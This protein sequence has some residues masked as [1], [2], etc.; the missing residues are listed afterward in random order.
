MNSGN[1]S[2]NAPNSFGT[3]ALFGCLTAIAPGSPKFW[4]EAGY[5]MPAK[6]RG[7]YGPVFAAYSSMYNFSGIC[8]H[9]DAISTTKF[10]Y[11]F[12]PVNNKSLYPH[13]YDHDPLCASSIFLMSLMFHRRDIDELPV[14]KTYVMNDRGMGNYK[15]PFETN[16]PNFGYRQIYAGI[17]FVT[18][19]GMSRV[20]ARWDTTDNVTIGNA[21]LPERTKSLTVQLTEAG[22]NSTHE[23]YNWVVTKGNSSLS[24]DQTASAVRY[25]RN[26]Q[27]FAD[28]VAGLF[29]INTPRTQLVIPSKP[30]TQGSANV[31]KYGDSYLSNPSKQVPNALSNSF[32]LNFLGNRFWENLEV[33]YIEDGVL[34]GVTS[35]TME[36]IS[37]ASNLIVV[38]A[39]NCYNKGATWFSNDNTIDSIPVVNGGSGFTSSPNIAFS[40]GSGN[41]AVAVGI[42]SGGVL[43]GVRII[44]G[45]TG[46]VA[47]V[48]ATVVDGGGTGAVLGTPVLVEDDPAK[49]I[50]LATPWAADGKEGWPFG[51]QRHV[52][53]FNLI[54]VN[55]SIPWRLSEVNY[56][57]NIIASYPV[58]KIP[59]GINVRIDSSKLKSSSVYFQLSKIPFET[60]TART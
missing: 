29:G 26:R 9:S 59:N 6:Y 56:S 14:D 54:G 1:V 52:V 33:N 42:I 50:L 45:G 58:R 18:I 17:E 47:G 32:K 30:F 53:D 46:Y 40:G 57:G 25:T 16:T 12:N 4:T 19:P 39:S 15:D 24:Q 28:K 2:N 20:E 5:S 34:L 41:S 11:D 48:T 23:T 35:T 8:L 27:V 55:N 60:R 37:A 13:Q 49:E 38:A 10:G 51:I 21:F 7:E 44:N 36:P 43:T 3:S 22:Y 31:V